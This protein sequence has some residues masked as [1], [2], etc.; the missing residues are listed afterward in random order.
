M[1]P[2][3]QSLTTTPIHHHPSPPQTPNH[4]PTPPTPSPEQARQESELRS[5]ASESRSGNNRNEE[6]GRS[7]T[8][9]SCAGCRCLADDTALCN[10]PRAPEKKAFA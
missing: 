5:A 10:T 1:G 9:A 8:I 6:R 4:P 3:A 7:S 2:C